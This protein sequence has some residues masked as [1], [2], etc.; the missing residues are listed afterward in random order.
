MIRYSNSNIWDNSNIAPML[1]VWVISN[2]NNK[3]Y[4]HSSKCS[5][6]IITLLIMGIRVFKIKENLLWIMLITDQPLIY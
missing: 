3:K 2:N 6:I 1:I 4:S 5:K